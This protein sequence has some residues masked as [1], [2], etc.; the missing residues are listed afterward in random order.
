MGSNLDI[1]LSNPYEE[2][3]RQNILRNQ[4]VLNGLIPQALISTLAAK[5][6]PK[7]HRRRR[8]RPTQPVRRSSRIRS[9]TNYMEGDGTEPEVEEEEEQPSSPIAEPPPT[10]TTALEQLLTQAG[11]WEDGDARSVAQQ[12]RKE[13]VTADQVAG[14][15]ITDD[16]LKDIGIALGNRKRVLAV[17][18]TR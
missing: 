1:P 3:R 6:P 16:D 11:G 4:A 8:Q 9:V 13:A 5:P 10:P 7:A 15:Q 18:N 14:G 12:L 17:A 2:Q